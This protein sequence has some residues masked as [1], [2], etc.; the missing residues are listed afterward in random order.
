MCSISLPL[1]TP[2]HNRVVNIESNIRVELHNKKK[3]KKVRA[4][5]EDYK[6]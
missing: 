3:Y 2:A 5:V 6:K 1:Y 4:A